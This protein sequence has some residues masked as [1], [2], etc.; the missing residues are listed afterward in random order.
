MRALELIDSWPVDHVAAAVTTPTETIALRGD[1][2]HV[3]PLASVTKL[4]TA[5]A[6]LLA[7]E[8]GTLNLDQEA[9]PSG[10]TLR[11]L[12]AHASGMSFEGHDIQGEP[13]HR[14][15]YSNGGYHLLGEIVAEATGFTF[16]DYVRDGVTGP[17]GMTAT[18]LPGHAG[19]GGLGSAR[20][21]A[22]IGRELLR[23]TLLAAETHALA[24]RVAFPGLSGVLPG[25]GVQRPN[26]WGLGPEIRGSKDPHWT[27]A[28]N[29]RRTVG[30]FGQSGTFCWADPDAGI[31]LVALTDRDFGDWARPLW[32]ALSDAVL[33]EWES[34]RHQ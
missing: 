18:S 15:I 25:Y 33:A 9:G 2:A 30:H 34:S 21:I 7:T 12:L 16:E 17:L 24:T 20:D 3:F 11:H 22:I 28:A 10:S 6:V 29:S 32:P 31:S 5:Q 13:G 23:P 19:Q 4:I 1:V 26:D 27:G 8:D 14:R